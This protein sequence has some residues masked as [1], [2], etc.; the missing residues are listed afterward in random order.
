M[1]EEIADY[2]SQALTRL[3]ASGPQKLSTALVVGHLLRHALVLLDGVSALARQGCLEATWPAARSIMEATMQLRFLLRDKNRRE[4][5]AKH[6]YAWNLLREL[7]SIRQLIPGTPERRTFQRKYRDVARRL[8]RVEIK[9]TREREQNI[10]KQLNRGSYRRISAKFTNPKGRRPAFWFSPLVKNGTLRSLARKVGLLREYEGIYRHLSSRAH[11]ADLSRVQFL[12]NQ[13]RMQVFR[14]DEEFSSAKIL[15]APL[16]ISMLVDTFE[17]YRPS[18]SV[19]AMRRWIEVWQPRLSK[20]VKPVF[21][22][23]E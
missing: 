9:D 22:K 14:H 6:L 10:L 4:S 23:Q 20:H 8:P 16:T 19:D 17:A 11:G 13:L 2:G 12:P 1:L 7:E 18:E 5:R 21:G 15:A 3:L